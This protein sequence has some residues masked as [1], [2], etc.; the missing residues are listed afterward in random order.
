MSSVLQ[1]G[2]RRRRPGARMAGLLL[3]LAPAAV[4][5]ALVVSSRHD[6]TA[7][8]AKQWVERGEQIP[9]ATPS[10][11]TAAP[12]PEQAALAGVDAFHLRFKDP[13]RSGLVDDDAGAR[14]MLDMQAVRVDA[15]ERGTPAIQRSPAPRHH[16]RPGV[17]RGA[18]APPPTP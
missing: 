18:M 15:R 13:P 9:G 14:G 12:D 1:G 2:R 17:G 4:V 11:G 5:V 6:N 3:L 7:A 10:R 8:P 16:H